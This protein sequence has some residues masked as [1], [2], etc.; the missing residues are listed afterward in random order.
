M[1]ITK[2]ACRHRQAISTK[3]QGAGDDFA[4]AREWN[5]LGEILAG[6]QPSSWLRVGDVFSKY[7]QFKNLK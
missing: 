7:G 2:P 5:H 6:N 1:N 3:G 4:S